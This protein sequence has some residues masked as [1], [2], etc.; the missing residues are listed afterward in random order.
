MAIT[1]QEITELT[2]DCTMITIITKIDTI[3]TIDIMTGK[4]II[5]D[6]ILHLIPIDHR[7]GTDITVTIGTK[8]KPHQ[9]I[10]IITPPIE[11]EP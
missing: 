11:K 2:T 1:N 8:T 4:I 7:T 9:N 10:G 6:R 5:D 3:A